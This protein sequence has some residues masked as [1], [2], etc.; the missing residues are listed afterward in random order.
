MNKFTFIPD[1][2][3]PLPRRSAPSPPGNRGRKV[4]A[5]QSA[6]QANGLISVRV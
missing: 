6:T 5:T 2:F 1:L 3:I 4:R